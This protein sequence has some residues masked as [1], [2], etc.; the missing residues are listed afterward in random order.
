MSEWN[1]EVMEEFS[2]EDIL[3]E[4]G[5]TEPADYIPEVEEEE[6]A[7]VIDQDLFD[8]IKEENQRPKAMK[9]QA[10]Q[11]K[12][13]SSTFDIFRKKKEEPKEKPKATNAPHAV[14]A[15]RAPKKKETREKLSHTIDLND[16]FESGE[17]YDEAHETKHENYESPADYVRH[18]ALSVRSGAFLVVLNFILMLPAI[19]LNLGESMGLPMIEAISWQAHPFRYL[20][21]LSALLVTSV[22]LNVKLFWRGIR[23]IFTMQMNMYSVVSMSAIA[24]L[25]HAAYM[26]LDKTS[27]ES[28]PYCGICVILLFFTGLG[29]YFRESAR[30]RACKAASASKTPM[31]IFISERDGDINLIKHPVPEVEPFTKYVCMPDGSE[32]FWTY[33]APILI[34]ASLVCAGISALLGSAGDFFWAYAAITSVAAPFFILISYGLPFSKITKKLSVMGAALGGWYAAFSLSGRRNLIMRDSDLFPKG[35]ISSHGMKVFND[36]ALEKIVAYATSMLY[37][38]KSG[39]YPLFSEILKSH[40]GKCEKVTQLMHHESGGMQGEIGGDT[41]LL[42]T[43]SFIIRMGVK[44]LERSGAKNTMYLAIN[45]SLAAAFNLKYRLS[46]DVKEGLYSCVRGKVNPVLASVDCNLTPVMIESDMGFKSG[47]IDYPNIEER[48]DLSA[49]EQYLEYDPSA[50]ITRA[51]LTPF[52]AAVNSARR[53]RKVTIRNTVL[54]TICAAVGLLLMFYITFVG[55]YDAGNPYNVFIYMLLWTLSVYLLSSRCNIN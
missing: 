44:L 22:L 5:S 31:G 26:M 53:L 40:Y 18:N 46:E 39:L 13:F 25:A 15:D 14:P 38:A 11:K 32:R 34:V 10:K 45:G 55:A 48:L 17:A 16:L 49:E 4:F 29:N 3:A 33:L 9:K 42:G 27:R 41:V 52:A 37:A 50:F 47:T 30:L 8:Q 7:P 12:G 6:E 2:L 1:D 35:T 43:E 20:I 23:G 24:S 51:G 28:L 21:I 36:F 19:Y 54:A